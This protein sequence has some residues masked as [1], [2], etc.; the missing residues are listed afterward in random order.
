MRILT[1]WQTSTAPSEHRTISLV[2]VLDFSLSAKMADRSE[3]AGSSDDEGGSEDIPDGSSIEDAEEQNS[4]EKVEHDEPK[5]EEDSDSDSEEDEGE[6][7]VEEKLVS[8]K[9]LYIKITP[10]DY[11]LPDDPPDTNDADLPLSPSGD[12]QTPVP[13]AVKSVLMRAELS[14]KEKNVISR[15]QFAPLP[16]KH[17]GW[18]DRICK[19]LSRKFEIFEWS[20]YALDDPDYGLTSQD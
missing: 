13:G 4:S 10:E 19:I 14:R 16:A 8:P 18:Y 11:K 17:K 15:M 3:D 12:E 6:D 5:E 7:E 20:S 1:A 9:D 2:S